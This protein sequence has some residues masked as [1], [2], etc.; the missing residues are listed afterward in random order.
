MTNIYHA[1]PFDISAA[2][3]Y[4]STYED[5]LEKS[6]SNRNEYC[7]PVEEYEILFIDGNN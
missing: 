4:F 6:A 7:D 2:G 3:F 5:Y 1:T